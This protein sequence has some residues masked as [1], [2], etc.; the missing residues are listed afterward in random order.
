[1]PIFIVSLAI[2]LI[3]YYVFEHSADEIS[4]LSAAISLVGLLVSIVSAPWQL[5]L[6][7]FLLVAI[8]GRQL[9]WPQKANLDLKQNQKVKP[10]SPQVKN[11]PSASS[12]KVTE[13][14][15]GGKY[16]GQIW[17]SGNQQQTPVSN[18][19]FELKYRGAPIKT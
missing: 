14:A 15:M 11:N 3:A 10:D 4:Y 18:S 13:G 8:A 5:L 17:K 6:L 12:I 2:S 16:R 1:M 7:L 9:W 19:E